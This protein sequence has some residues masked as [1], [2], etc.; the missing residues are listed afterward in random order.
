MKWLGDLLL[1]LSKSVKGRFGYQITIKQA[2]LFAY[3]SFLTATFLELT[4]FVK[5]IYVELST[6]FPSVGLAAVQFFPDTLIVSSGITVYI[7]I[8]TFKK[9]TSYVHD[10]WQAWIKTTSL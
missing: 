7:G 10:A 8:L 9:A 1:A 6:N 4:A 3:F 5:G 2:I